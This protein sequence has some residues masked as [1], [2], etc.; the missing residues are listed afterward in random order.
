[1]KENMLNDITLS[2]DNEESYKILWAVF[3]KANRAFLKEDRALVED[4]IAERTLCG[5]L[6]SHLEKELNTIEI[7]GK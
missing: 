2:Y 7:M 6:K 4:D 3:H 1:M 5:T